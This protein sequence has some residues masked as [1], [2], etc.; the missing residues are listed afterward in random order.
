MA[1]PK[2]THRHRHPAPYPEL[3]ALIRARREELERSQIFV[4]GKAG[5]DQ[6][7]LSLW[8]QGHIGDTGP[9]FLRLVAYLGIDAAAIEA[10]IKKPA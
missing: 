10:A 5:I 1:P 9:A 7:T 6:S 8:E 4:S 3:G 2:R